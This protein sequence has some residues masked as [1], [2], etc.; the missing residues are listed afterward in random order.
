MERPPAGAGARFRRCPVER[1]V[2]DGSRHGWHWGSFTF[3][4]VSQNDGTKYD[5]LDEA[6]AALSAWL[7]SF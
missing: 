5:H 2:C 3:D 7:K 6:K 1:L 4:G